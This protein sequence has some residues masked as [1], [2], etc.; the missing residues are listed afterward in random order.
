MGI[1]N[2]KERLLMSTINNW[3]IFESKAVN[4]LQVNYG[5]YASFNQQGGE[6]STIPDI[7]VITKK[8]FNRWFDDKD[9]E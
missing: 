6:D 1:N 4:Y 7:L 9:G 8:L 5:Q 2:V 3:K